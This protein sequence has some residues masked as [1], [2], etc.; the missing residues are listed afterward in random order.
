[1]SKVLVWREGEGGGGGG[2]SCTSMNELGFSLE[3]GG[4]ERGKAVYDHV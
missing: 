4:G 1:M 3:R 2:R